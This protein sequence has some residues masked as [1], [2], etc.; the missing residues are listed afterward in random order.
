[1]HRHK[2]E[3]KKLFLSLKKIRFIENI[4]MGVLVFGFVKGF[5]RLF[6]AV[7]EGSKDEVGEQEGEGLTAL[8]IKQYLQKE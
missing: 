2:H 7:Y 5:L 3:E 6:G 4:L 1:M 8:S